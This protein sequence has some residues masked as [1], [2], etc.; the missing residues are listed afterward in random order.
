MLLAIDTA[1]QM[2]SLALY[3]GRSLIVEE[4]WL[5]SNNHTVE[6]APAVRAL[7]ERTEI[8]LNGLTALAVCTG[9]GTFTGLR[10]GVSLA[11]GLASARDLPLVGMTTMDILA[12][13]QP[14]A[15]GGLVTVVQAG[16]GRIIA[17]T[18]QWR[19]GRWTHRGEPQLMAWDE[20]IENID[21]PASITGEIDEDGH[22]AL[23]AARENGTPV[24]IIPAAHRLRRAGFLAQEAWTRLQEGGKNAFDAEL[25][26]PVYVK[27]KDTP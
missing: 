15:S 26:V 7:F 17:A 5:S 23:E 13:S 25:V 4:T 10:I 27:T 8:S 3:D 16:R 14:Q 2:T 22:R 19:K 6:L 18:H 21:G 20:L 11:K 1:T 9:P 24:T 12:L